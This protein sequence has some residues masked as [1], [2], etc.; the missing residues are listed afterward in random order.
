TNDSLH[1]KVESDAI[2]AFKN[3]SN[4]YSI[5]SAIGSLYQKLQT[6]MEIQIKNKLESLE[7]AK[8]HDID[9]YNKT[10]KPLDVIAAQLYDNLDNNRKFMA[11]LYAEIRSLPDLELPQLNNKLLYTDDDWKT[12]QCTS[13]VPFKNPANQELTQAQI[14]LVNGFLSAFFDGKNRKIFSWMM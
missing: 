9:A 13:R 5:T 2:I 3:N 8:K 6:E 1:D 4:T 7:M 12:A 14:D 10:Y 11:E